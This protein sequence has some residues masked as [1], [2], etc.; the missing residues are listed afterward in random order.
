MI[1]NLI[2]I[3]HFS[4]QL[5]AR[6]FSF[7]ESD[8]IFFF[9]LIFIFIIIFIA[10]LFTTKVN[11]IAIAKFYFDSKFINQFLIKKLNFHCFKLFTKSKLY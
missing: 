5:Y 8:I 6:I 4:I 9:H 2:Y 3:F 7:F 10:F 1:I 11:F